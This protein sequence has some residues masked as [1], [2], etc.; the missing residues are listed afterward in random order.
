MDV[1]TLYWLTRLDGLHELFKIMGGIILVFGGLGSAILAG[2]LYFD[3]KLSLYKALLP[4]AIVFSVGVS[5]V[6]ISA[7]IPKNEDLALIIGGSYITNQEDISKLPPNIAKTLNT[8][9][10]KLNKELETTKEETSD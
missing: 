9:L 1:T 10:Q 2:H 8:Y 6:I 4:L 3:Q 7:F 5:A